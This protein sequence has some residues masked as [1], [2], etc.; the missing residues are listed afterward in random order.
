MRNII[1]KYL[2]LLLFAL[3]VDANVN[4]Y[5]DTADELFN[6]GNEN[7]SNG[8]YELAI[9]NYQ[10]VLDN[11]YESFELFYNM[12]NAYFRL[13]KV[14]KSILYYEKARKINPDDDDLIQNLNIAKLRTIDKI[15]EIDSFFAHEILSGIS[16]SL[17]LGVWSFLSLIFIWL[18]LVVGILF[19]MT[20]SA[21]S[22][23]TLFLVSLLGILLAI[24]SYY[25]ASVTYSNKVDDSGA[26][27]MQA[28][29][30]VKSSPD[31][32]GTDLFILHEGAK[33]NISDLKNGWANIKLSNGKTGWIP[34]GSVERI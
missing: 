3:F 21:S 20:K 30:Y 1:L 27:L 16:N 26:I 32:S 15:E 17:G 8:E 10:T 13:N 6:N 24:F 28:S 4:L 18:S 19:V 34:I 22:K 5:G 25:F 33:L 11:G 31:N 9:E 14:G 29:V 23:K 2:V 12:G 7:Y